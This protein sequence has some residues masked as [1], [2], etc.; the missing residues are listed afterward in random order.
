[1]NAK[2]K[3]D[4]ARILLWHCTWRK[5]WEPSKNNYIHLEQLESNTFHVFLQEI[6]IKANSDMQHS[7]TK[8]SPQHLFHLKSIAELFVTTSSSFP[9]KQKGQPDIKTSQFNI[10]KRRKPVLEWH[11]LYSPN[12][13]TSIS[14]KTL[15]Q[16]KEFQAFCG[17]KPISSSLANLIQAWLGIL[18]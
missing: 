9:P 3:H 6:R 17:F 7:N 5:H 15:V 13:A 1:M 4:K 12:L 18:I 2:L 10:D 16:P 14:P 11:E 8:L